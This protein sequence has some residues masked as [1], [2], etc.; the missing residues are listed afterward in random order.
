MNK[1][2]FKMKDRMKLV[3]ERPA[4]NS[5]TFTVSGKKDITFR[6]SK[7]RAT[8]LVNSLAS[9]ITYGTS[10]PFLFKKTLKSPAGSIV[11]V[12]TQPTTMVDAYELLVK[13]GNL[14]IFVENG[15]SKKQVKKMVKTMKEVYG[16]E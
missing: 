7:K 6:F 2:T 13:E 3:V 16:I 8:E 1:F 10:S 4:T 11:V 9:T 15:I 12:L 5:C 14:I